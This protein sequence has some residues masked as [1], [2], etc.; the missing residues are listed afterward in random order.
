MAHDSNE[1]VCG[2]PVE[3][4]PCIGRGETQAAVARLTGHSRKTIRGYVRTAHELGWEPGGEAPTETLASAV[5]IRHRPVGERALGE[6]EE[7]LLPH[8]EQIT[9]WLEPAPGQKR[10]LKLTKDQPP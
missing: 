8:L 9:A 6:A 1:E 4:W 7:Q 2:W 5:F 10:G 3:R